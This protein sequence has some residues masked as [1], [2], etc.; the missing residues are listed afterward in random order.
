MKRPIKPEILQIAFMQD[1]ISEKAPRVLRP[2][3]FQFGIRVWTRKTATI[4]AEWYNVTEVRLEGE[5]LYSI[6]VFPY[7]SW[8]TSYTPSS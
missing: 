8:I 6:L 1:T 3:S 2:R 7:A 4:P 5:V